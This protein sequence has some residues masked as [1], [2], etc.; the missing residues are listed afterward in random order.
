MKR[1]TILLV[2]GFIL[3]TPLL[4]FAAWSPGDPL[5]PDLFLRGNFEPH[6]VQACHL[7]ELVD[8]LLD[9]AVYISA[10]VATIMFVYAGF[11]YV[12]AASRPENL[13]QAKGIFGKVFLGFIIVLTAWL[14]INLILHVTTER[15]LNIWTG[16][17]GCEVLPD[18]PH[19]P[20]SA[21]GLGSVDP[22]AQG[23]ERDEQQ[24]RALFDLFGVKFPKPPCTG[25][26]TRGCANASNMS[27][28]TIGYSGEIRTRCDQAIG[29]ECDVTFTGGS[30]DGHA[31]NTNP[32]SHGGGDKIDF[33]RTESVGKFIESEVAEERFTVVEKPTFGKAQWIDNET[34]AVWTDEG[35]HYDVCVENCSAP[36]ARGT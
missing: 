1:A 10:L 22:S 6:Q 23:T 19:S 5:V 12:T 26:R 21:G 29:G 30:E 3:F 33:A 17:L 14:I 2:V 18:T 7:V 4:V 34:G 11:L 25:G 36:A 16:D 8:N 35:D 31:G 32:G 9:F 28:R 15:S 20:G 27:A 13:N 24:K